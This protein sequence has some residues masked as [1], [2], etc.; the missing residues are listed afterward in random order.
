ML[1]LTFKLNENIMK[2]LFALI[3]VA[4]MSA[5]IAI[6]QDY[7]AAIEVF[8]SAA[9]ALQNENKTEALS[10]FKQALPLFEACGEEGAEMVAKCKEQI[11][12][13][14]L[15]VAKD[16]IN[17]KEYDKAIETLKEAEKKPQKMGL[18]QILRQATWMVGILCVSWI[19][20]TVLKLIGR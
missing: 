14:T 16:L 11:P 6:A 1:I 15:S 7:N 5:G 20:V 17:D 18:G 2:R 9:V 4:L 19:V 3:T 13:V 12:I 10:L 8:N